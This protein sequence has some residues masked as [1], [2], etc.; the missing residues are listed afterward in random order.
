MIFILIF[1]ENCLQFDAIHDILVWLSLI[2]RIVIGFE[3]IL[4]NILPPIS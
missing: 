3:A 4:E 1:V 2:R